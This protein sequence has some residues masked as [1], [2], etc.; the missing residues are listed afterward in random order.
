MLLICSS[1]LTFAARPFITD[2][3]GINEPGKFEFMA[4]CD[5]WKDHATPSLQLRHGLTERMD[6]GI[7]VGYTAAPKE[8]QQFSTVDFNMKLALIKDILTLGVSTTFGKPD[9]YIYS[10]LG[11]AFGPIMVDANLGYSARAETKDADFVYYAAAIYEN[12]HFGFGPE[13]G[14]DQEK[15]E[16][17]AFGG[18]WHIKN[19]L[20]YDIG[21]G[22]N[23][24]KNIKFNITTG[25]DMVFP[26]EKSKTIHERS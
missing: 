18:R 1:T 4:A 10:I 5:F 24:K 16:W 12:D 23:F 2:D 22:G 7:N 26:Q 15:L 19:W 21:I 13:F 11:K 14:G 17:W 6:F 20:T 9:Y 25:I 3:P 8:E